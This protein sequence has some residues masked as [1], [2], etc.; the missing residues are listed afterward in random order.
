[1][2]EERDESNSRRPESS[3]RGES[4]PQ[5]DKVGVWGKESRGMGKGEVKKW[6]KEK[7]IG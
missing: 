5:I 1:V 6:E 2:R 7:Q 3:E 4:V